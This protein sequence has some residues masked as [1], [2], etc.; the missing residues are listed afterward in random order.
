[1]SDILAA[2]SAIR[3]E[4]ITIRIQYKSK[5]LPNRFYTLKKEHDKIRTWL[6][7]CNLQKEVNRIEKYLARKNQYC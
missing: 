4:L 3:S 7:S 1:M 2:F 6:V 5:I